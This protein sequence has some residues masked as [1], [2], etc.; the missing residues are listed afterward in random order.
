MVIHVQQSTFLFDRLRSLP[1][2]VWNRQ[3]HSE[4]LTYRRFRIIYTNISHYMQN[5]SHKFSTEMT[6]SPLAKHDYTTLITLYDFPL[7]H[8]WARFFSH[9][10]LSSLLSPFFLFLDLWPPSRAH[11]R[12]FL[13]EGW[14]FIN[15]DFHSRFSAQIFPH[16]ASIRQINNKSYAQIFHARGNTAD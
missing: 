3:R 8:S 9:P 5:R 16:F 6:L 10:T 1:P 15:T 13:D 7:N 4:I 11:S 14:K 12:N 2:Q